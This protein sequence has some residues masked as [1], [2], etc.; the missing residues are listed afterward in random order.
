MRRTKNV[1]PGVYRFDRESD[2]YWVHIPGREAPY[3]LHI[4][5]L[6][7]NAESMA[8]AKTWKEE[9]HEEKCKHLDFY[10][11][12]AETY[13]KWANETTHKLLTDIGP[14]LAALNKV[15]YM[16]CG[17][18]YSLE[19][20]FGKL[21]VSLAIP[22]QP[23]MNHYEKCKD[24]HMSSIITKVIFEGLVESVEEAEKSAKE[25]AEKA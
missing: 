6:K 22:L 14:R 3:S 4:S 11:K 18:H 24:N 9:T 7:M 10:I 12:E 17:F 8:K 20:K 5:G 15:M 23:C 21:L 13:N 2:W 1:S 25:L 16:G 19:Q